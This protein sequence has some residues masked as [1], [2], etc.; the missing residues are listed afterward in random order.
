MKGA[1]ITALAVHLVAIS[2]TRVGLAVFL[3]GQSGVFVYSG[4]AASFEGAAVEAEFEAPLRLEDRK[5]TR[6]NSSH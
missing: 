5:S 6:M 4:V 3:P 2:L 1:L